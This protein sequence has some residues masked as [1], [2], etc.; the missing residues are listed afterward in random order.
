ME[1]RYKFCKKC[2]EEMP[3]SKI[4]CFN[5]HHIN[6]NSNL[7]IIV[8]IILSV[9]LLI[10]LTDGF[11]LP[12]INLDSID[13]Y[14][15]QLY[16]TNKNDDAL[17]SEIDKKNNDFDSNNTNDN[18]NVSNGDI[19]NNTIKNSND[20]KQSDNNYQN[21]GKTNDDLKSNE[22]DVDNNSNVSVSKQ[23]ALKVAKSYLDIGGFS[24]S[25]LIKQLEYEK[26]INDDSVYAVDNC[27]AD[28]NEQAFKSAKSYLEMSGFSKEGLIKQLEYEGF[29]H[30][31]AVYGVTQTGL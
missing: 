10:K 20:N 4:C 1:K 21:Q 12:E 29:T 17:N 23:N 19:N 25:G 2:G 14:Y 30:E 16:G 3:K 22:N 18:S 26:F 11:K 6:F 7:I 27:G 31:E 24:R 28:W 8:V 5:C 9:W 13:E 15:D